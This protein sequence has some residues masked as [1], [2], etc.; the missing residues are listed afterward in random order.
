MAQIYPGYA[1]LI[2]GAASEYE[3]SNA[4][5]ERMES[6]PGSGPVLNLCGQLQPRESAAVVSHAKIFLGHD[7]GPMHMAAIVQTPL[8]AIFSARN[9]P[10]IWYPQG[11]T[12]RRDLSRCGLRRLRTG[13]MHDAEEEVHHLDHDRRGARPREGVR[14]AAGLAERLASSP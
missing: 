5:A 8:V 4:I 11:P 14:A 3:R 9:M 10:G 7:S 1:L 12:A 6:V 13:D 2:T